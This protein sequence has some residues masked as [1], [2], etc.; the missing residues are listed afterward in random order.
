MEACGIYNIGENAFIRMIV[1]KC[2]EQVT[3]TNYRLTI[4]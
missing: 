3:R 4:Q 2:Y 1:T